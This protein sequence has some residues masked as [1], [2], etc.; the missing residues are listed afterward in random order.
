MFKTERFISVLSSQTGLTVWYFLTREGRKG[1]FSSK[2]NAQIALHDFI[3]QSV[4]RG[5]SNRRTRLF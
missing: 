4:R 2:V 5:R 1:P 3:S